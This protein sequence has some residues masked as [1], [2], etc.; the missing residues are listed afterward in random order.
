MKN[1]V[2]EL[3]K[4]IDELIKSYELYIWKDDERSLIVEFTNDMNIT[5]YLYD[6]EDMIDLITFSFKNSEREIYQI[7]SLKVFA[8]LL[9]NVKVYRYHDDIQSIY[10]NE[11]I[12]PYLHVFSSNGNLSMLF[13]S[14]VDNQETESIRENTL[15]K[16]GY[17]KTK[18]LF[19][20]K[21]VLSRIDERIDL[22]KERLR[23]TK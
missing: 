17:N 19:L 7:I 5:F 3:I 6:R 11:A 9:G 14:L 8:I 15:V 16:I 13:D 20:T 18:K 23:N 21:E 1:Y 10:Y 12:K 22:S 4:R 2:D